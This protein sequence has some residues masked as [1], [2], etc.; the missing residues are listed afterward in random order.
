MPAT[1]PHVIY[2]LSDEHRGQA[3][4]HAGDANLRTPAMDRMAAEG[5][6]FRRAYANCPVCTPSRGTIFSGRHAHAGPVPG[7]RE[8]YKATAP[9]TATV[10]KELGYRTAYFGKWHCGIVHDQIPPGARGQAG[11]GNRTPEHLRAGFE[12]WFGF[13]VINDPFRTS[14]YEGDAVEPTSLE[15]YQ[16]DVLTDRVIEYLRAYD[17]DE[18][19]FLV[20]S[21]EPP[22]FPLEVPEQWQRFDPQALEV[23]PNFIERPEPPGGAPVPNPWESH[24]IHD[25]SNDMRR[26]L[27]AYY[28]MIENLDANIGRLLDTLQE[29]P[30]FADEQTLSVYFSD[31]GDFMGSHG[32]HDRKEHP[33]EECT[34]IPALFHWPGVLPAQGSIDGLFGLVDLL[35]TTCGLV[36]AD[37]PVWVQGHDHSRRLRGETVEG[38]EWQLLEMSGSPRW[39]LDFVDWRA[40]VTDHWKYAFY[41]T[42]TERLFDLEADP[43]ELHDL[44]AARPERREQMRALL[45]EALRQTREPFFDVLIEHGVACRTPT[46]VS[47]VDYRILWQS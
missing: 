41:E 23:R 36:G 31:H 44:T 21:V 20:L 32:L 15:G 37:V 4:A 40:V 33:Q 46:N 11:A 10:L 27:A 28:A 38:P 24:R 9:S 6:S 8:A 17:R 26:H 25:M 14:I 35:P 16:T 30:G 29:L 22:H 2:V 39:C 7:F 19:L 45:L 3:M 18:P 47:G 13:E 34:R 5:A 42:G 43:Y 12:D 1:R